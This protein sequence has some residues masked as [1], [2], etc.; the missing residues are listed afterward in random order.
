MNASVRHFSRVFSSEVGMTPARYVEHA[1]TAAARRLLENTDDTLDLIA[2]RVG[3]GTPETLYRAFR[4][5]LKTS[6]GEYRRR[7]QT[8]EN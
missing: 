6:P 3:L 2:A 8:V 4:R 1:R 7:F 5:Q